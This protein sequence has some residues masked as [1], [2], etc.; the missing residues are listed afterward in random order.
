MIGLIKEEICEKIM[1]EILRIKPKTYSYLTDDES[2]HKKSK[3]VKTIKNV[4]KMI[5]LY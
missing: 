1:T 2:G 5:K 4:Y 3:Q